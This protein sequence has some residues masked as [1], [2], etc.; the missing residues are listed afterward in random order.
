M[1]KRKLK[2]FK[3]KIIKQSKE[4]SAIKESILYG[5]KKSDRLKYIFLYEFA[6]NIPKDIS[7]SAISIQTKAPKDHLVTI[8]AESYF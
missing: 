3:R 1:T 8:T 4:I 7:L 6:E 2:L 5:E